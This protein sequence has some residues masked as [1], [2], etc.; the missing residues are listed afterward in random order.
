MLSGMDGSTPTDTLDAAAPA[1]PV[2][3]SLSGL[4]RDYP[5][6]VGRVLAV[7]GSLVRGLVT[8][9]A[10]SDSAS[11]MPPVCRSALSCAWPRRDRRSMA[12]LAR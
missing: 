11:A 8:H 2:G 10:N 12:S 9:A 4:R 1:A 6:P 7:D 3:E 5:R